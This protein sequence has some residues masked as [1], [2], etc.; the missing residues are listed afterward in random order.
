VVIALLA[1]LVGVFLKG[2]L[3]G[4]STVSAQLR[5]GKRPQAPD[6]TL[7]TLDG[8][9]FTLSST[10]G[11]PV[12]LNFW[13]SWC[14]PC[15]DEAPVLA[16]L[17]HRYGDKLDIVGVNSQD[18][19]GDARSFAQRYGLDF[20]VVHDTGPVYRKWGLGGLP[21]TFVIAP[22]GKVV[23]HFPGQITGPDLEQ[24]LQPY[25]EGS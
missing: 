14:G 18:D 5:D 9:T 22:D 15:K 1:L 12:V 10:R 7:D 23:K 19:I 4:S 13:A 21:E 20:T 6:F 3:A 2:V 8:G 24:A 17:A 11:K 25:V 16:E